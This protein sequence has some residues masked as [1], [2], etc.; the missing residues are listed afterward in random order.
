MLRGIILSVFSTP[1]LV[2]SLLGKSTEATTKTT[3]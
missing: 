3:T 2:H 1:I